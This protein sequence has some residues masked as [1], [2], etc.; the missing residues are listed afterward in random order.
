L[1]PSLLF[2]LQAQDAALRVP[3]VPINYVAVQRL[4]RQS[5][6]FQVGGALPRLR[7]RAAYDPA[8]SVLAQHSWFY[9]TRVGFVPKRMAMWQLLTVLKMWHHLV[10]LLWWILYITRLA[11]R[12]RNAYAFAA[13]CYFN[14]YCCYLLGLLVYSLYYAA[15][16]EIYMRVRPTN[17]SW[18]RHILLVERALAYLGRGVRAGTVGAAL[19]IYGVAPRL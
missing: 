2:L 12:R 7:G 6:E 11:A 17:F 18:H 5:F 1:Y 14:I 13:V 4:V 16:W 15:L 19:E 3:A 8:L 10:I 9:P